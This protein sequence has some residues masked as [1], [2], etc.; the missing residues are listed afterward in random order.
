[1][2]VLCDERSN[3]MN[4]SMLFDEGFKGLIYAEGHFEEDA[5][6]IR[7]TGEFQEIYFILPLN[8]CGTLSKTNN[9]IAWY[10][11]RII[12]L[13]GQDQD[14]LTD[15]DRIYNLRCL[16]RE[17]P[18][19]NVS[20]FIMV[21]KPMANIVSGITE[22]RSKAQMKIILG[23]DPQDN[24]ID[25]LRIGARATMVIYLDNESAR[26]Y[27]FF[28]TDCYAHDGRKI[29][30]IPLFDIYGCPASNIMSTQSRV[31]LGPLGEKAVYSHFSVFKFPD[32]NNVYFDC[33]VAICGYDCALPQC[34][35]NGTLGND[36]LIRRKRYA[37]DER[38]MEINK[39]AYRGIEV[40]VDKNEKIN[41]ISSSNLNNV[42]DKKKRSEIQ[43]NEQTTILK[44]K[45]MESVSSN[46]RT[47]FLEAIGDE[48]CLN[49][50]NF[51][52][53]ITMLVVML[54]L[55]IG[56]FTWFYFKNYYLCKSNDDKLMILGLNNDITKTEKYKHYF[57]SM[58][59]AVTPSK[60]ERGMTVCNNINNPN[61][62]NKNNTHKNEPFSLHTN[63]SKFV[64]QIIQNNSLQHD[65]KR[66]IDYTDLNDAIPLGV[67]KSLKIVANRF[68]T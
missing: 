18:A 55:L 25:T 32:E 26:G 23:E 13:F 61:A 57:I 4:M 24:A 36:N 52:R 44:D 59:E 37:Q 41:H 39:Y 51:I 8:G 63:H 15:L 54:A 21:K 47:P 65:N 27:N 46:G 60:N 10:E 29:K 20:S 38:P 50:T 48:F 1:V 34:Q 66:E 67:G 6:K 49:K 19:Y 2:N 45:K 64:K 16:F 58:Q 5:C 7:G 33:K 56:L 11:N 62:S 30:T 17:I 42:Y 9:E 35:L 40:T 31:V 14:L 53:T 43:K 28:I 3:E 68:I 22:R 12:L